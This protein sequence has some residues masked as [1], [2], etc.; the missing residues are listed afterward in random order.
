MKMAAV[1]IGVKGENKSK[2]N[3]QKRGNLKPAI[4][5]TCTI[6]EHQ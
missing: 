1:D 3:K 6:T 4:K 2:G 5:R